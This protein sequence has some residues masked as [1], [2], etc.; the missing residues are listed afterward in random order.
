MKKISGTLIYSLVFVFLFL[1]TNKT[2]ADSPL[3]SI[4]L[5]T[6]FPA[7]V[8]VQ[9]AFRIRKME[10]STLQFIIDEDNS[11]ELKLGVINALGWSLKSNEKK[12]TTLLKYILK[13][14]KVKS[15][16]D[17]YSK[18]YAELLTCYTYS[19]A[20]DNYLN[21]DK[22]VPLSNKI[23]T[24]DDTNVLVD[25][26]NKLI[27][28]QQYFLLEDWCNTNLIFKNIK[29][30]DYF[31]SEVGQKIYEVS[32]DYIDSYKEYCSAGDYDL[33]I[34][35]NKNPALFEV[36]KNQPC[37]LHIQIYSVLYRDGKMDVIADADGKIVFSK[38][39]ISADYIDF[40]LSDY[41]SATY[42]FQFID[43]DNVSKSF[44]IRK[45]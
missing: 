17:L 25:F 11:L 41:N 37:K 18:K 28:C 23:A 10:N 31:K 6:A 7:D 38:K 39:F 3:T 16:T 20:L 15:I 42:T 43:I 8:D 19:L 33:Y 40:D 13:K 14:Y 2:Y 24:L 5:W 35:L 27:K 12:S 9:K 44:K 32:F 22:V 36:K 21:V 26:I 30:S 4:D 45:Y 29:K 1:F 34:N